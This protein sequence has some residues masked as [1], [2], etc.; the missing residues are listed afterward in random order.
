MD[1]RIDTAD[2]PHGRPH[3][4]TLEGGDTMASLPPLDW[5]HAPHYAGMLIGCAALFALERWHERRDCRRK[6]ALVR[7]KLAS[8]RCRRCGGTLGDWDGR[9][10]RGDIHFYEGGYVPRVRARCT[11]CQVEQ[12]FYVFC[13]H[14]RAESGSCGLDFRLFNRDVLF[15]GLSFDRH[16]S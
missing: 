11:T 15:E 8:Q 7:P 6:A 10:D 2:P 5:Q 16:D 12:V 13:E 1:E 3:N 4:S 14:C 9:F